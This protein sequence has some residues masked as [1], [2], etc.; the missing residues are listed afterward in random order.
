MIRVFLVL[1]VSLI[2]TTALIA[3][4]GFEGRPINNNIWMETGSTLNRGEFIIGLGT[5]VGFG[6][7][8][9][10][11]VGT[12]VLGWLVQ[13]YNANMKIELMKNENS[14][15]SAGIGVGKLNLDVFGSEDDFNVLAPFVSYSYIVSENTTIHLGGKFT[16]FSGDSNIDDADPEGAIEGTAFSGGLDYSWS[17]KTKFLVEGGYDV[18][19]DGPKIGGAILWG[20]ETLRLKLGVS[21]FNPNGDFSFTMPIIGLYW[22][23]DG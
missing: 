21:Y 14:S 8:D 1:V 23:F 15:L 11:Q 20:W 16:S 18:T 9:H 17:N 13:Y 2:L 19:F 12:N 4:E 5:S 7:T 10:V 3:D 22:R 6:I